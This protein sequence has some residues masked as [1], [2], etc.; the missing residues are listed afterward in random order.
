LRENRQLHTSFS[1]VPISPAEGFSRTVDPMTTHSRLL[2][3]LYMLGGLGIT[4]NSILG[5]SS[6]DA[7]TPLS[8]VIGLL[9]GLY[10]MG[11]GG[12]GYLRPEKAK[13][14]TRALLA[15]IGSFLAVF[16]LALFL[17]HSYGITCFFSIGDSTRGFSFTVFWLVV[18]VWM[19]FYSYSLQRK[20]PK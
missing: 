16:V 10:I 5:L 17:L 1:D 7:R 20:E 4:L 14:S 2:H 18:S 12:Y 11:L 9:M 8:H 3:G 19:V 15:A 13:S 6:S